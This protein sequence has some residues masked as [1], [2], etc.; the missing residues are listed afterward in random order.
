MPEEHP[1]RLRRRAAGGAFVAVL[2]LFVAGLVGCSNKPAANQANFPAA[3]A[4]ITDAAV[5]VK[6]LQSA[7]VVLIGEGTIGDVP[8]RRAD[9]ILTSKDQAKGTIQIEQVGTLFEFEFVVVD[10]KIHFKGP[11]GGWRNLPLALASQLYDPT[12]I[13]DPDNG[14]ANVI[15]TAKE[16][17]TEAEETID[18]AKTYK[19]SVKL[20]KAALDK[21]VPGIGDN[22]TGFLW[23][24][25]QSKLLRKAEITVPGADGKS[26]KVT[27]TANDFD[28]PVTINA[29]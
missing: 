26:G 17:K 22:A 20:D 7:H 23:L 19:V 1:S 8:L 28:A 21:L 3:D 27:I 9:A 15:A 2:A 25:A 10:D 4:L 11:T 16:P 18:G 29:P 6:A 24:D 5:A 12:V 13:L 14:V